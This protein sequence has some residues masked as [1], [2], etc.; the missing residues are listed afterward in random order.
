VNVG[1]LNEHGN[2]TASL[3]TSAAI[4]YDVDVSYTK[5]NEQIV[6]IDRDLLSLVLAGRI[7]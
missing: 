7:Y 5:Q 1:E 3:I 6:N 2:I 4:R